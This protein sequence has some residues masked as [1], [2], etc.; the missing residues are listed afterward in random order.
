M[1][2]TPHGDV[3]MKRYTTSRRARVKS[4]VIFMQLL[5]LDEE[6]SGNTE[7]LTQLESMQCVEET[8]IDP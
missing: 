3:H 2:Q 4:S 6:Y 5:G 7:H 8:V 1:Q